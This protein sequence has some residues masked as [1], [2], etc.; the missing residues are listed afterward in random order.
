MFL[1]KICAKN[2]EVCSKML[3][4]ATISDKLMFEVTMTI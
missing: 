4:F 2:A 3:N 1:R